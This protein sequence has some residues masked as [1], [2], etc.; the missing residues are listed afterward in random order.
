MTDWVA[1]HI[2]DARALA[3]GSVR[4]WYTAWNDIPQIGGASEQGT[5]NEQ[6]NYPY[7]VVTQDKDPEHYLL[8]LQAVGAGAI[9]VHDK[10]SQE[11]YKDYAF[12]ETFAGVLPL[13][14]DDHEGDTI[15]KV[16]RRFPG[17][18][19]VVDAA[20][21]RSLRPVDQSRYYE[22]LRPYVA[23]MEKG[24]D[25]PAT[26]HWDSPERMTIRAILSPGQALLIQESYD[27]AWHAYADGRPVPI[28][29]DS[30]NFM[31]IEPPPG[32]RNLVL[33]FTLP[34]ENLVGYVLFGIAAAALAWLGW[35]R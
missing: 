31:L 18:A 14:Y 35:R 23:T 1:K 20:Q 30:M 32:A 17:L 16:P 9:V 6:V 5:L 19:H 28:E 24:P 25:V 11:P 8:A 34:L 33:V 21:V 10:R 2:P 7:F 3:T 29:R 26:L 15:Y 13:L 4:F 27:P 12:P 22:D